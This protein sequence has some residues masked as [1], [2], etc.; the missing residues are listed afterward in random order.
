[1]EPKSLAVLI[2]A[3]GKSSRMKSNISKIMHKICNQPIIHYVLKIAASKNPAQIIIVVSDNI[4]KEKDNI[5]IL[6]KNVEFVLQEKQLGTA[7]AVAIALESVVSENCLI[8]YGDSPLLTALTINLLIEKLKQYD[9]VLLVFKASDPREYG[10]VIVDDDRLLGI[11]EF[12]EANEHERN[13]NLCNSGVIAATSTLL[14]ELIGKVDN[15]NSKGE[16][17][18]TDI[19]KIARDNN[20]N[21][22]Y[23]ITNEDEVLGVNSRLELAKAEEIMQRRLRK[24]MMEEGVTL[25]DPNTVF[26]SYDTEIRCDSV[27]HPNVVFGPNVVISENV[28]IKSFSH[29]EGANIKAHAI[30]GP[31]ARIRPHTIIAEHVCIGNFVEVKNSNIKT[32]AKINHLSYVGDADVGSNTNIGAGVITCNYD[33]YNKS[34]TL[35][36]DNVFVGSNSAL[37]AP[38]TICDNAIIGAGSVINKNVSEGDIAIARADQVNVEGGAVEY[39]KRKNN[40]L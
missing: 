32:K 9:L 28:E 39:R 35:I 4:S 22:T 40:K 18:L 1:M 26:F 34:T 13:V 6:S 27:I 3:A 23:V 20:Y 14:K 12:A 36:G 7:N 31:F 16:Y 38:V 8:L 29:I 25:I 24:K 30:I 21:I 2:L 17:Y 10:R 37:I 19:I 15:K 11:V 5:N 33:G